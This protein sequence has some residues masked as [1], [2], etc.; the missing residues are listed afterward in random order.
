MNLS[1]GK[2]MV[3]L[4]WGESNVVVVGVNYEN[5]WFYCNVYNFFSGFFFFEVFCEG[6][7]V[8]FLLGE[9]VVYYC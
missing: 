1:F 5:G 6:F 7:N 8:K 3:C 9:L 2:E 4:E